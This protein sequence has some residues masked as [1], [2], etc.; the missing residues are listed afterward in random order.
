MRRRHRRIHRAAWTALAVILPLV[1]V[2]ALT[3]RRDGPLE[4]ASVQIAPPR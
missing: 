4:A 2:V 1:L 3:A